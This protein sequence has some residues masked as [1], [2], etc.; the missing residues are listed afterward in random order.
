[1][2]RFEQLP[3]DDP[4]GSA[5]CDEGEV[6]FSKAVE[7]ESENARYAFDLGLISDAPESSG[8]GPAVL[9]SSG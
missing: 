6:A 9:R 5:R 4:D 7:L 2:R 3:G 8:A 1:M